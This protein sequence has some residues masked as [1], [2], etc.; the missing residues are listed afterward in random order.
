MEE[1]KGREVEEG[2]KTTAMDTKE[3]NCADLLVDSVMVALV[4]VCPCHE[5]SV[6]VYNDRAEV[7]RSMKME[8]KEGETAV[9]VAGLPAQLQKDSVRVAGTAP[10]TILQVEQRLGGAFLGHPTAGQ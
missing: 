3:F 10:A 1:R 4:I 7:R 9:R 8:L 5:E 6:E 2:T